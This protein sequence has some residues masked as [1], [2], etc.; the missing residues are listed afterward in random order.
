MKE[1]TNRFQKLSLTTS[2]GKNSE[3]IVGNENEIKRWEEYIQKTFDDN[4][5][6]TLSITKYNIGKT[7]PLI[8]KTEVIH[9]IRAQKK[10][11]KSLALTI[12]MSKS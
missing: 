6:Q 2:R 10:T 4:R 1:I 11:E 9:S 8:T 7:Y 5:L 3:I 12:L